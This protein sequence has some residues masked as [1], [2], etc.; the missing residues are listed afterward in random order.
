[1]FEENKWRLYGVVTGDESWFYHRQIGRKQS[2]ASWEAEGESR[3]TVVR[4]GRFEPKKMFRIF[5]KSNCVVH[6]SH[7]N[8]RKTIGQYSFLND[9]FKPLVTAVKQ[10]RPT[11]GT[12]KIKF[13]MIIQ[14]LM[15]HKVS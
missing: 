3:R 4:Q 13:I 12:K 7:L 10:Q 1:M 2:N 9:C 5:F 11:K 8:K 14:N 15:L 6:V